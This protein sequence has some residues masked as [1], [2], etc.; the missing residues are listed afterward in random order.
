[1]LP[2]LGVK[3]PNP[4]NFWGVNRRFQAKLSKY[5]KFH[6][7]ETTALILTKFGITIKT[8]KWSSWV[9]PV[10]AQQ[11]QDGG[12]PPFKKSVK[13]PYVCDRSTDFD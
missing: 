12:R 5:W 13:S 7:I 10:G 2:I 9:V 3:Y 4:P 8:T 1:M 6:V 11:L